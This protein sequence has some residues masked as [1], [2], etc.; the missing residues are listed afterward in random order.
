MVVDAPQLLQNDR[1][2][3]AA[4]GRDR[5]LTGALAPFAGN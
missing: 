2:R 4:A 3:A 5:E 1:R